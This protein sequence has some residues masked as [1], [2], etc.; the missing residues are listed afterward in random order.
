MTT[1]YER[2]NALAEFEII[3]GTNFTLEFTSYEEIGGANI[4]L[5][6]TTSTVSWSAS[7]LGQT[8]SVIITKSGTITDA[9]NGE[10]NVELLKADTENLQGV[11]IHQPKITDVAGTEFLPAQGIF[12]IVPAIS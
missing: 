1:A 3:A 6:L 2:V 5:D 12:T 9:I 7:Y 4:L 8:G 11:L 10:W